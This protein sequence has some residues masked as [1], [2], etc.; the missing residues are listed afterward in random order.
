M[1]QV[2]PIRALVT[3]RRWHGAP[4]CQHG[5]SQQQQL[6]CLQQACSLQQ[7]ERDH[8]SRPHGYNARHH[9]AHALYSSQRAHISTVRPRQTRVVGG[10]HPKPVRKRVVTCIAL[11]TTLHVNTAPAVR[12]NAR[13]ASATDLRAGYLA[14]LGRCAL[15]PTLPRRRCTPPCTRRI[16]S[17]E[18]P[19]DPMRQ[20]WLDTAQRSWRVTTAAVDLFTA[21][22]LLF[23]AARTR[24]CIATTRLQCATS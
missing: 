9:D 8:A 3:W 5:A 23:T 6:T 20:P 4:C 24:P 12:C 2:Q 15:L 16:R 18:S 7:L 14:P 17:S 22:L 11:H 21:S 13:A 19:T 1:G 10:A